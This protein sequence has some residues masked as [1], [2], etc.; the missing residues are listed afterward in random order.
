VR[1]FP[2]GLIL[3][4]PIIEQMRA[5]ASHDPGTIVTAVTGALG[6]A[7]G[8]DPGRMRLQALV[9]SAPRR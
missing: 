4:N 6:N 9:F 8:Q 2:S 1:R 7:F 3:G 5:R